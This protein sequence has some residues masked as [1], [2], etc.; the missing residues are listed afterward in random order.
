MRASANGYGPRERQAL[1][2]ASPGWAVHVARYHLAAS[3]AAA[4]RVLDVACGT[5]YGLELL[6]RSARYVVGVDIDLQAA[7]TARARTRCAR[8]G[9]VVGDGSALPFEDASFPL[10]VSFETL[11]HLNERGKFLAELARVVTGD[12]LVLLSTPNANH[13]RPVNGRPK[14]P[15]HVHEYAPDELALELAAHFESTRLLGQSL[16][17]RFRVPPFWDDQERVAAEGRRPSVQLWR[18]LLRLPRPL[19]DGA[20]RMLWNHPLLPRAEDYRFEERSLGT[21]EVLVA[22]CRRKS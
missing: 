14:N 10:V 11:E 18:L 5:G 19:A 20:S 9:V 6:D 7:K 8:A 13:T 12:G 15:Y 4:E 22:F 21:A 3:V 2:P 16:D 1:D 17:P